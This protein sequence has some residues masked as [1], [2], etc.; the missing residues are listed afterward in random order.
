MNDL[1]NKLT[2][3]AKDLPKTLASLKLKN[4]IEEDFNEIRQALKED[5]A[6]LEDAGIVVLSTGLHG[7]RIINPMTNTIEELHGETE[8]I[9]FIEYYKS[10]QP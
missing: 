9:K 5:R 4:A 3:L 6:R 8:T 7:I 2:K 10:K 1:T